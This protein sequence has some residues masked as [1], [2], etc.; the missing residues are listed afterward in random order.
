MLDFTNGA[1]SI[2]SKQW[3]LSRN[4][5]SSKSSFLTPKEKNL[6]FLVD[7]RVT[8]NWCCH[9]YKRSLLFV[10]TLLL[11]FS[12]GVPCLKHSQA[13]RFRLVTFC[14]YYKPNFNL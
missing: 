14:V 2:L 5:D 12:I 13:L 3:L 11:A 4:L 9:R 6:V 10:S 1:C 8:S 7:E